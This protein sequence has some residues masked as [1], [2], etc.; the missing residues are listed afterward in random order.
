MNDIGREERIAGNESAFRSINEAIE[1][2]R[3]PGED[4]EAAFRCECARTGCTQML[5]LTGAAYEHLRAHSRR[6]AVAPG[7]EDPSVEDVVERCPG[8]LV[9]EKR[10]QAGR[11]AQESDP[12]S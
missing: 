3:W 7:H 6:F 9:V 10:S 8:Y 4:G 12:R 11:Y 1:R 5:K 2:G